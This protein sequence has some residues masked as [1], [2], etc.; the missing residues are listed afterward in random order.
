[1]T[2]LGILTF[3]LAVA[4]YLPVTL[5]APIPAIAASGPAVAF[6]ATV[7]PVLSMPTYGASAIS[8][9]GFPE[10]LTEGGSTNPLPIASI[11]KIIT[12]LVV[13]EKKPLA[14][15][16]A[17]PS[18][19]FTAADEAI[20]KAY[21]ARNG[22]VYPIRVGGTMSERD[23]LTVALVAS[24]NNYAR[25]LADWAFG[26]EKNFLPAAKAWLVQHGMKS[27][28]LTDSTGLNSANRSTPSDLIA[29]G[30]IALANPLVSRIIAIRHT[31]LPVVGLIENTNQLLGIEGI[32]GIKTGTLDSAGASLL[33]ASSFTVG[34]QKITLVGVILD[35]P[36]HPAIDK[37]IRRLVASVRKGFS[38]VTLST[39]GQRFGSYSTRWGA[40][41]TA[42]ATRDASVVVWAGTP[43]RA[44]VHT[45]SIVLAA[46][47]T[48]VGSAIFTVAGQTITVP[49]ALSSSVADPGMW[50]RLTH[51]GKL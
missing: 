32:N 47:G 30:K 3:V 12:T 13:L 2:V 1:M 40:K 50:W 11:T 51:P 39:I 20:R 27:T 26:S 21:L 18:I 22:D 23:V 41:T 25:A 24:A 14:V 19:P 15:G 48:V 16:K 17:G 31:R 4:I 43:V 46:K 49:L 10:V 6:P 5:L 34:D 7:A 38:S 9:I 8:A 28:T 45:D 36:N 44:S 37:Q 33:F 42:V 35:G 29:L